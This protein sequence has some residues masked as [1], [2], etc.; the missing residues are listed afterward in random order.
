MKIRRILSSFCFFVL[1]GFLSFSAFAQAET[2]PCSQ[3][4]AEKLRLIKE[5]EENQFNVRYIA[6]QGNDSLSYRVFRKKMA[7]EQGDV[8]TRDNLFKTIEGISKIKKIYPISLD[9]VE[10]RLIRNVTWGRDLANV[11]DFTLCV[12]EKKKN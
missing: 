10:I 8:F 6:I 4:K 11:V 2:R 9:D 1:I 3:D 12:K 5:A 7:T